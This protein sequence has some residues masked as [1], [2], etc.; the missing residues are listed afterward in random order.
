VDRAAGPDGDDEAGP[1]AVVTSKPSDRAIMDKSC[2][3]PYV[4]EVVPFHEAA[5]VAF[6]ALGDI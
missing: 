1:R 2:D 6:G 5:V 4:V 3:A